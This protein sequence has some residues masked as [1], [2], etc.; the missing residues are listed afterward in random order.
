MLSSRIDCGQHQLAFWS[1]RAR[2]YP[3]P[4][5]ISSSTVGL[6]SH[7]G[8]GMPQGGATACAH[9]RGKE[10]GATESAWVT[11][12][13]NTTRADIEGLT[14]KVDVSVQRMVGTCLPK[15]VH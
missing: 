10:I 15:G 9:T 8:N 7:A 2:A 1:S 5:V 3:L 6:L 14:C 12:S 11:V 13:T 4:Q